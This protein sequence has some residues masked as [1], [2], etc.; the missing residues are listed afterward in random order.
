MLSITLS[1]HFDVQFLLIPLLHCVF[2]RYTSCR[3]SGKLTCNT[4]SLLHGAEILLI[5]LPIL[6]PSKSS[7]AKW[8]QLLLNFHVDNRHLFNLENRFLLYGCRFRL[9]RLFFL[10]FFFFYSYL[11]FLSFFPFFGSFRNFWGL[12]FR[13]W[14]CRVLLYWCRSCSFAND[15]TILFILQ[16]LLSSLST[17]KLKIIYL[18]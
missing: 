13:L 2:R 18:W 8:D 11:L 3:P 1:H 15:N 4:S 7:L 17:L 12:I 10:I 6:S 9:L 16:C 5:I 14:R